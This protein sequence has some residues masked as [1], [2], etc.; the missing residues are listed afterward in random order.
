MPEGNMVVMLTDISLTPE[1]TLGRR[2]YNFSATM[3][4]IEDGYSLETLDSLGIINIKN[5]KEETGIAADDDDSSIEITTKTTIGQMS[6]QE[7][8]INPDLNYATVVNRQF[9]ASMDGN[10]CGLKG[11]DYNHVNIGDLYN[12]I[13]YDKNSF[14]GKKYEVIP[15]SIILTDLQIEFE[16]KPTW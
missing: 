5:E 2:L 13:I 8:R 10:S 3:Y 12:Y 14:L 16:S 1:Q 9:T 6:S 15:N 11:F 4:E 7:L